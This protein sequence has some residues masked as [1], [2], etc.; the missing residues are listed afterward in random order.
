MPTHDYLII[1]GGIV[2]LSTAMHLV[3][4][5]PGARVLILEKEPSIALHQTGRN[6][7]V[8]HSGIY[9]KPGSFKARF[10]KA[11][12]D[13]MVAFCREHGIP[14]DVCGKL[15][16]ATSPEQLTGLENL[17]QRGL[18]NGVPVEKIPTE[19]AREIE[20]HVNCVA[21]LQVKS[22]GITSYRDVCLEYLRQIEAKGGE[23]V[24]DTAVRSVQPAQEGH[25]VE[26]TRGAYHAR[27]VI[28]CAGL[29]SDRVA[30][31]SGVAA[32]AL[33]VPFR[34][35]Y[36]EL[37]PERRHLV[38]TLIYPVPNPDFPFLGVHFTRMIDGSVHAGPN[39]VLAFA[40]E[41][42]R[43]RDI[44]LRDLGETL[45]SSGFWKMASRN[46]GEGLKE[47]QRSFS[48]AVF[49]RSLQALV[50]EVQASDLRPCAAGIRAQALLPDGK[51]VDDFLILPG[52]QMLHVCNAP[53]PAA[54]ASLEIGREIASQ[55]PD[56]RTPQVSLA[57]S[58][59]N[60]RKGS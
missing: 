8:I 49:T 38:K 57:A 40:R 53:S 6:S 45:T 46:L 41:G 26:T 31:A 2:G 15:I 32:P 35:E 60:Q 13:S 22:T 28:N 19:R 12:A 59:N 24:Y 17:Y 37:V 25:V 55:V 51:L 9:Y 58:N 23:V 4:A 21:A 16:V 10:A 39:A 43:K 14:F 34:G 56:L 7:G 52:R 5:Y 36:Y 29:Y 1:G 48:K 18:Q 11:G 3:Q 54:T 47:M 30:R 27:F 42:Y 20:P 33:I 50:P 44:N